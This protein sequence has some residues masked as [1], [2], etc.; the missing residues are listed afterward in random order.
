MLRVLA[1]KYG[2]IKLG[3]AEVGGWVDSRCVALAWLGS[4]LVWWRGLC[5]EQGEQEA[6][7]LG[8]L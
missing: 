3:G 6:P 7:V 5:L 4:G 2:W 1:F 8:Q